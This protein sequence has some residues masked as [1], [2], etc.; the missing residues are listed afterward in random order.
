MQLGGLSIFYLRYVFVDTAEQLY[1]RIFQGSGVKLKSIREYV[2]NGTG[3]RIVICRIMRPDKERFEEM[4]EHIRNS[5]LLLG[6][7]DYDE[8]CKMLLDLEKG[9][10]GAAE[11][12][13]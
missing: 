6:H 5:A 12:D 10:S 4:V 13:L 9:H 7:S 8:I 3:L 2:K 1:K 11:E